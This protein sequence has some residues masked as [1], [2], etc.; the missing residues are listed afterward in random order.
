V[1]EW[2]NGLNML[3]RMISNQSFKWIK[4]VFRSYPTGELGLTR[5]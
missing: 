3:I 5:V 2:V 1:S 4:V